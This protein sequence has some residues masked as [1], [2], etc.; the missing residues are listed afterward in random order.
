MSDFQPISLIGCMYKA[1]SKELANRLRK[2]IHLLIL[3]CQ[4]TFIKGRQIFD[5]VLIANELVDDA[6]RKKKEAVYFKVDFEKV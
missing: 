3:D 5:G 4:S 1:L 6:K 2:V